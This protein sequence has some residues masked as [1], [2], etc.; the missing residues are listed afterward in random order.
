M[1]TRGVLDSFVKQYG[2]SNQR[3]ESLLICSSPVYCGKQLALVLKLALKFLY[4]ST[5]LWLTYG[6]YIQDSTQVLVNLVGVTTQSSYLIFYYLM[7]HNKV[8]N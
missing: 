2:Q 7:T 1:F 8:I 6:I 3:M 5:F 4:S